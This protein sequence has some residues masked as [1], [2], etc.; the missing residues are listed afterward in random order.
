MTRRYIVGVLTAR[1]DGY[2]A[3]L[4]AGSTPPMFDLDG[5]AYLPKLREDGTRGGVL[6][7]S[8]FAVKRG[9]LQDWRSART[10]ALVGARETDDSDL[11]AA[12]DEARAAVVRAKDAWREA[13]VAEQETLAMVAARSRRVK[14]RKQEE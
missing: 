5:K 7:H 4:E 9:V 10:N 8:R 6:A 12:I 2:P 11:I 1:D 3:E 14:V 13:I